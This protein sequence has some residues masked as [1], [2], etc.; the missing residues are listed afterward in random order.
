MAEP[1]QIL[2]LGAGVQSTCMAL[3][4]TMAVPVMAWIGQRIQEANG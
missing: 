4:N 2:S 1:L 3:G